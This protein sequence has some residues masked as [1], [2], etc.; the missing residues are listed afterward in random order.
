MSRKEGEKFG[1]DDDSLKKELDEMLNNMGNVEK[2]KQESEVSEKMSFDKEQRERDLNAKYHEED[3]L[4]ENRLLD[5]SI[6]LINDLIENHGVDDWMSLRSI[7]ENFTDKY[8]VDK[9]I[10]TISP[11]SAFHKNPQRV[12]AFVREMRGWIDLGVLSPGTSFFKALATLEEKRSQNEELILRGAEI[13]RLD[14]R[15]ADIKKK[16]EDLTYLCEVLDAVRKGDVKTC[17]ILRKENY[18]VARI[19]FNNLASLESFSQSLPRGT[20]TA[21]NNN[22][23]FLATQFEK[24][25]LDEAQKKFPWIY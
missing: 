11:E 2:V 3:T 22:E 15:Q 12:A 25:Q 16:R 18:L 24:F 23:L 4:K 9:L 21:I 19:V 5:S 20:D 6:F 1:F 10:E 17:E 8:E 7:L 13:A 14:A